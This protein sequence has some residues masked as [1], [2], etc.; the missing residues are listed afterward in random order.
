MYNYMLRADNKKRI[1]IVMNCESIIK[2]E[3]EPD[4]YLHFI[5]EYLIIWSQKECYNVCDIFCLRF[6]STLS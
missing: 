6:Y 3:E 4:K 5:H 1:W 2:S